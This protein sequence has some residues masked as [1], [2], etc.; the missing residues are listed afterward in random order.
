MSQPRFVTAPGYVYDK[1]FTVTKA[2]CYAAGALE[3]D[4]EV[5]NLGD[6]PPLVCAGGSCTLSYLQFQAIIDLAILEGFVLG[7]GRL[8]VPAPSRPH[9]P[10][11][12]KGNGKHDWED[13]TNDTQRLRVPGGWLYGDEC[14]S[15]FVPMPTC[16]GYSI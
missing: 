2:A 5:H 3:L 1:T 13:V 11:E 8:P 6:E 10:Q 14:D 15:T 9:G 12:Y 7:K 16:V 4:I